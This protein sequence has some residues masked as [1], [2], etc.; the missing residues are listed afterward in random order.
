MIES[1]VFQLNVMTIVGLDCLEKSI[2]NF[3]RE[4]YPHCMKTAWERE[5]RGV[6]WVWGEFTL[7]LALY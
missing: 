6:A 1:Q 5:R 4:R 7:T 3:W 2:I